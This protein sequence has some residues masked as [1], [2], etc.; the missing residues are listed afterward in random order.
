MIILKSEEQINGI[1]KSSKILAESFVYLADKIKPGI[2]TAELDKI[3]FSYFTPFVC[4]CR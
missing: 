3:V 4:P 1:R 2:T